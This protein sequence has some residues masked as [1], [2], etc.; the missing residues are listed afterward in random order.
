MAVGS[1]GRLNKVLTT[2]THLIREDAA[3]DLSDSVLWINHS[4]S[5]NDLMAV[6]ARRDARDSPFV[7]VHA[8]FVINCILG[9]AVGI[10]LRLVS[11][12]YILFRYS[13]RCRI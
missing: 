12:Y 2:Q 11:W 10:L 13:Y 4:A 5:T 6:E 3:S 7:L 1:R 9:S 8:I